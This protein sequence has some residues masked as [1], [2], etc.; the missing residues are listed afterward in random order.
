MSEK[1]QNKDLID[2]QQDA[3]QASVGASYTK[4]NEIK[5]Q[6][7]DVITTADDN[8]NISEPSS[9]NHSQYPYNKAELSQSGHLREVDDTPGAERIMEMHKSGTFY[10]IHP[11]GTRVL[12]VYG[13]NF[14]IAL[15]DNNLVVGGDLNI[16]VQGDARILTKGDVKQ[17]IGGNYDLTVHGDMTTR[18]EGQRIDY[19]KSDH[20]IQT[21]QNLKVRSEQ[22]TDVFSNGAISIQSTDNMSFDTG[23]DSVF[24]SSG[25]QT[26]TTGTSWNVKS[27]TTSNIDAA[28]IVYIDGSIVHFNLPGPGVTAVNPE[29]NDPTDIDPTGGLTIEGSICDPSIESLQI[30]KTTNSAL[31]GIIDT[32]IT[33][34]KDRTP[35]VTNEE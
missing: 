28:G 19:T 10:E 11:D 35:F 21:A 18:V 4:Q 13:D 34:P 25:K 33:F 12:R 5:L 8:I 6:R 31:N 1:E 26:I 14:E 24:Y 20:Q 22:N 27:G 30:T 9:P 15:S 32:E 23:G 7:I 2:R 29:S 16:T 17:K 3:P